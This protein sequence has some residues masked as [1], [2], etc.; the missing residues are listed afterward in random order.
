MS[1]VPAIDLERATRR[2]VTPDARVL[3]AIRDATMSVGQRRFCVAVGP[4]GCGKSTTLTLVA[5]LA[6]A[7]EGDVRL[8]GK[9]FSALEVQTRVLLGD[10]LLSLWSGH[11]ASVPFIADDLEDAVALAEQ[12][13]VLP[14]G[15]ATVKAVYD[16]DLPRPRVIAEIR[17]GKRFIEISRTIWD[18]LRDEVLIGYRRARAGGRAA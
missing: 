6:R 9:P 2:F 15:P 1:A 11:G 3:T 16:I 13:V 12:V 10:E 7:S 14:A 17:Y 4:T 8:M 5:G 18:D